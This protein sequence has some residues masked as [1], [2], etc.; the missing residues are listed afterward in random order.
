MQGL[1][2]LHR[3][4]DVR[5]GGT[6]TRNLRMFS[7]LCG[8]DA[9]K[10]VVILTTRWDETRLNVA[11][12]TETE[13]INTYFKEFIDNGAQ[14]LR[15][16]NTVESAREVIAAIVERPPIAHLQVIDEMMSGRSL[17]ETEAG[18]ELD[19]QLSKLH[20]QHV[21][22]INE[23]REQYKT[24]RSAR[25]EGQQAEIKKLRTELMGKLEK[26]D[27]DK[28]NLESFK[29][30]TFAAQGA[31]IGE[32]LPFVPRS[33]GAWAGGRV[34]TIVGNLVKR[35]RD[36]SRKSGRGVFEWAF[37]DMYPPYLKTV[38]KAD[39]TNILDIFDFAALTETAATLFSQ[40]LADILFKMHD[41]A[42]DFNTDRTMKDLVDRN[43]K[44]HR[45]SRQDTRAIRK[46]DMYYN[47]N[48]GLRDDW[49]TDAAFGQQ[50][51]TGT[52]TTTITRAPSRLIDEFKTVAH[53]QERADVEKL[54]E[55]HSVDLYV[56]DY[57][58]FR[59]AM[60][61]PPSHEFSSEGRYGCAAVVLF[62]LE[63]EGKLHPLAITLDHRG[64]IQA[65]V[66][67]FNRRISSATPGDEYSDWPWRYAKMCAQVS[68]WL[69][70]EVAVHLVYTHLVE[71]IMIVSA[72]R[73]LDLD[74]ILF[75]LLEPHWSTTLSLNAAARETLV[76]KI[77]IGMTGFTAEETYAFLKT[78][79]NN[80]NWTDHY[81]PNDLR[82][83]GFPPEDLDKPKYHNYGYARNIARTWEILRKFVSKV[84]TT[85]YPGGDA[86]VANDP[87]VSAFCQEVRSGSGGQQPSFP[88]IKTLDGLIDFATMCIHVASP[89]HTAVN[90]LQQYYQT[91]VPNK[92]S[93][94]CA[95]L[96][97]SL[98]ELQAY[99]EQDV[100]LAL[101][102]RRQRDWLIMAQVP[103]LLS[104][105]M[106]D[107]QTI[108]HY[109]TTTCNAS[110]TP[111][112]I[113]DAAKILKEDLEAF[114]Y[115][116]SRYSQELD[117]QK[118]PYLVLDPSK[119]AISIL[120]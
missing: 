20:T 117:D 69:R 73:T 27:K 9:M 34:G 84:L 54:L 109:A 55:S 95:R 53:T 26:V 97:Q 81:V 14:V 90:Y 4:S 49:Y 39:Q 70:H 59:T 110:S 1:I 115:T 44:L 13:L 43:L 46:R 40:P 98:T 100:L 105:E 32:N 25:D 111:E 80:F 103:Y 16:D 62:H 113:R 52:N 91:F 72:H 48:I 119:T 74:H 85:A 89:Q 23:L 78:S 47:K 2:Y 66:T 76:P 94:L 17:F 93:A 114:Q 30:L 71:E 61:L 35:D 79:Y 106:L 57:S 3:I 87:S 7:R 86:Q 104:F 37:S 116:V 67:I 64:T 82:K 65:S 99:G 38:P 15:H 112:I 118:T 101:P 108:L 56:E 21:E 33:L 8:P 5:F 42:P 77:I 45:K 107:D 41:L 11:Q 120:I 29:D 83:R 51:F 18:R 31:Q 75:K 6:A 36:V 12:R 60:G 58:D 50:H 19:S 63:P 24:A 96:P 92:P 102:V 28:K 68:D 10:N 88:E 22:E